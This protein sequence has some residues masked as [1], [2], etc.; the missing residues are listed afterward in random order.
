MQLMLIRLFLRLSSWISP[1]AAALIAPPVAVVLR[2]LS[3]RKQ[4]ITKLNLHAAYPHLDNGSRNRIARASTVHYVRGALEAGMLWHWPMEKVFKCF[5]PIEGIENFYQAKSQGKGV[6]IASPHCGAWEL[7][8]LYMQQKMVKTILYKPVRRPVLEAMLLDKRGRNGADF[9]PINSGGVRA[10]YTQLKAGGT[11]GLMPDQ[12]PARVAGRFAPFFGVEALSSVLLPR[13]VQKTGAVVIFAVCERRKKG[14]FCIHFFGAENA[15]YKQDM[16]TALS[17]VNRG[18][19]QCI[20]IDAGQYLW[21]YK[22]FKRRPSGEVSL[23]R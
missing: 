18:L 7:M 6:I 12:E 20:E 19:E 13:L 23:Y 11:V 14:R 5:D 4:R 3:P 17:A 8:G 2:C 10:L 21:A 22:R 9:V 1:R 16:R 15:L